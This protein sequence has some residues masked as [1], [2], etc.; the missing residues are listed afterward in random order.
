MYDN[1]RGVPQDFAAAASWYR[2]AANKGFAGAQSNLGIM[3]AKGQGIPQDYIAA[4]M[5]F[6]LAAGGGNKD[7]VKNRDMIA[8]KMTPTQIAEAQ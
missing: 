1:G 6:N 8:A 5:W 7:A 2:K 3:Y 4:H